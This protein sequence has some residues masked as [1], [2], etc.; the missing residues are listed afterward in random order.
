LFIPT[1][2]NVYGNRDGALSHLDH[3]VA[4]GNAE[5]PH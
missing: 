3:H 2:E 1:P 4:G 5:P